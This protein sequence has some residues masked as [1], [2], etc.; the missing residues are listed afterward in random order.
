MHQMHQVFCDIDRSHM[1]T[2]QSLWSTVAGAAAERDIYLAA[3]SA[4]SHV[5]HL[6]QI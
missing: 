4:N 3:D 2:L 1:F 5:A 6:A